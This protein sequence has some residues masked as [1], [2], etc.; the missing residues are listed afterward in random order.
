LNAI[1]GTL[2]TQSHYMVIHH[3]MGDGRGDKE[4]MDAS[5]RKIGDKNLITLSRVN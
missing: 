1:G 5:L 2:V 4:E 3:K